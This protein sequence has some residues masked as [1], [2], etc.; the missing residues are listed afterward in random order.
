MKHLLFIPLVLAMA[1]CGVDTLGTAAVGAASKEKELEQAQEL[2]QD[3][4]DKLDA[5]NQMEQ[6]R[7]EDAAAQ[8]R[9]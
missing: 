4:R 8:S 2:K 3:V 9:P 7:L 1:G 6:Q 5:A